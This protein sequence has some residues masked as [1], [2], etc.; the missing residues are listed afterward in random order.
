MYRVYVNSM[1]FKNE[2]KGKVG[3]FFLIISQ[4]TIRGVAPNQIH[5]FNCYIL[6][7]S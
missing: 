3:V 6:G 7:C 4:K 5:F 1:S 2:G